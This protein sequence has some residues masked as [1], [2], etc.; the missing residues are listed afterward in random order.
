MLWIGMLAHHGRMSSIAASMPDVARMAARLDGGIAAVIRDALDHALRPRVHVL[1]ADVGEAGDRLQAFAGER[2]RE[3]AHEI[4][5][6][7]LDRV[8]DAVGMGLE[9]RGP[10]RL[11]RLRRHRRKHRAPLD[12]M[13]LAVL[14]HHVVAHQPV[15]QAGGL[16]RG[17]HVDLLLGDRDVVAARQQRR[18]ELR[19][20]GDRRF[21]AHLREHRIGI[22]PER[23]RV[24][25]DARR[26]AQG[27][28]PWIL[29]CF[30]PD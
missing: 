17:E 8:D 9:Q 30:R 23:G 13:R 6:P 2:Q 22:G 11:H 16:V 28:L 27:G 25:V 29:V 5:P 3:V 20:E 26:G 24:D 4:D 14:A 10:V 12:L 18:A 1:E 7:R 15:H 21:L 19:H